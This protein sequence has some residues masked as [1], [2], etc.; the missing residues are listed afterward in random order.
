MN[1]SILSRKAVENLLKL[2]TFLS[3]TAVVSFYS[4]QKVKAGDYD[5]VDYL[6]KV[7]RLFY[8]CVPDIDLETLPHFGYTYETYFTDADNLVQFVCEAVRDGLDIV[9]QCDYG[10]SRSAAC[11]VAIL[12]YYEKSGITIFADYR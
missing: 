1:V 9:C 8:A 12:E 4:P 7:S 10:Q 5:P 2:G 11:C 6:G 3:D